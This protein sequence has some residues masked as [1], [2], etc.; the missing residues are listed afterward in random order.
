MNFSAQHQTA[1]FEPHFILVNNCDETVF[2]LCHEKCL[3]E[4]VINIHLFL[5]MIYKYRVFKITC[6]NFLQMNEVFH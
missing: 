3:S 1:S 6:S 5:F 4:S 2:G